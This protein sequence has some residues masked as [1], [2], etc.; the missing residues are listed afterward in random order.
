MVAET[1]RRQ[2]NIGVG[3]YFAL[4]V[5]LAISLANPDAPGSAWIQLFGLLMV[6]ASA[7]LIGP[8]FS[9]GTLQLVL[10]KP[11]NRTVYLVSRVV[12]VW[13][14]ITLALVALMGI[15][16][17]S[18]AYSSRP[19]AW[20]AIGV[21]TLNTSMDALL[22]ASVI[23]F[24]GTFTRAYANVALYFLGFLLVA[25]APATLGAIRR[26][27]TGFFG[28]LGAILRDHP[29]LERAVAWINRNVFADPPPN[30]SRDWL[31]MV[32]GNAAVA[33]FLGALIFRRRE[34]PYGGD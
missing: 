23:A 30:F 15:E 18:I 27:E 13:L 24:L 1:I 29:E 34:V 26:Q 22:L 7:Q 10:A 31:L 32:L 5:L 17:A 28:W 6:V 25:S 33:L 8:E 16:A 20:A 14:A 4:L 11:I 19:V 12:G 9:T 2:I 3:M 21:R